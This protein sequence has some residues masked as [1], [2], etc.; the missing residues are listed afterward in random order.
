MAMLSLAKIPWDRWARFVLPLL[1]LLF[2]QAGIFLA[3]AVAIEL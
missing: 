1:G 2:L 3:V